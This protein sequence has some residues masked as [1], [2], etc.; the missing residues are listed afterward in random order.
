MLSNLLALLGPSA[1]AVPTVSAPSAGTCFQ[2]SG[3]TATGALVTVYNLGTVQI[4]LP[5][6]EINP[7]EDG[8]VGLGNASNQAVARATSTTGDI[9]DASDV[10]GN[11]FSF[12]PPTGTNF[13]IVP[14]FNDTGANTTNKLRSVSATITGAKSQDS[15]NG[16]SDSDLAI[17][18]GIVTTGTSGVG[19]AIVAIAKDADSSSGTTAGV[20]TY[21]KSGTS[22]N[23]ATISITGLGLAIPPSG[24]GALSGTLQAT[25]DPTPPTGIG[26]SGGIATPTVASAISGLSGTI[27]ICTVTSPAGELQ[28]ELDADGTTSLYNKTGASAQSNLLALGQIGTATSVSVFDTA[29]ATAVPSVDLEPIIIRGKAG[30]GTAA[31][32]QV[33]ATGELL[34]DVDSAAEAPSATALDTTTLFGNSVVSPI[35]VAFSDDNAAATTTLNAVDLIIDNSNAAAAPTVAGFST[36]PTSR[37]G[38][39]GALR[40]AVFESGNAGTN[41]TFATG[42]DTAWGVG[43]ISGGEGATGTGVD[44]QES[45]E[46]DGTSNLAGFGAI[47]MNSI[48]PFNN[49][50]VDLRLECG[51]NTNPVAGW[52]AVLNSGAGTLST[53]VATIQ[54]IRASQAGGKILVESQTNFFSQSLT[55]L[56]GTNPA[57]SFIG[58]GNGAAALATNIRD[59]AILYASCS[60]NTLTILPIQNGFDG[61]RDTISVTPRFTV[62]NVSNTFSSDINVIAQVSGNN[63]TGTTTLNLAKLV[64]VPVTGQNST[65]ASAE[66]VA[67]SESSQL[68]VDCSSGGQSSV[69]LA[70]ITTGSVATSVSS[71]CTSGAIAPAPPFWTGGAPASVSGTTVVDG[72]PVVQG[73][74]RGVLVSETTATG[75]S[76]LVNQVGGGVT[77]T[78][79]EIALP[80]GCDIIDDLDDNNTAST[81]GNTAPVGNDVAR[82]TVTSTAG[83]TASNIGGTGDALLTSA[84]SLAPKSG[85]TAAKVNFRLSAATGTG[86]DAVV[87]DSVLVRLD[88]QDIFCPKSEDGK[89]LDA[90]VI[91]KNKVSNPTITAN[92]GTANLGTAMT[93]LTF[94]FGDDVA[95]STKGE[96]STNSMIGATPRLVGGGATT[97]HTL[98]VTEGGPRGIPIGGRVSARNLDPENSL[99]SSVITRGQL[100]IIPSSSSAFSTAPAASD[101]TFSDNSLTTD[102]SPTIATSSTVNPNV[103]IGTLLIGVKK[104]TASGAAAPESSTTT[105]TVKN[106][107]L[108]SAT[109]SDADLIASVGVF[110]Q[111]AGVI[112]NTPGAI[113]GNSASS[114]TLFTPYVQ[115]STKALNQLEV[116]GVQLGT[117][118]LANSLL[119]SRL[120]IAEAPQLS[121]FAKTISSAMGADTTKITVA[122]EGITDSTDNV[123]TVTGAAGAVD[124][125]AEVA[126]TTGGSTAFDSVTVVASDDGSFTAKV[127]GDCSSA[128]S[129]TVT[130]TGSVSGTSTASV[131]KTALCSGSPGGVDAELAKIDG[132]G[133]GSFTVDEVLS[134]ITTEGG[135]AAVVSAGGDKLTAVI[136]A[137]KGALGLS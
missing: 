53:T 92:L 82:V 54:G 9:D 96:T 109:S 116:A 69:V 16:V 65:L 50:F 71:A 110:L 52:F 112:V 104:N 113:A 101:V 35:T 33:F 25:L 60:N 127:R 103:P 45:A 37:H 55:N 47:T 63:L 98:A 66:G 72:S 125:G 4:S 89:Q 15:T 86:T 14:G 87:T 78:V 75:F 59:N 99:L 27:N 136:Q 2:H 84:N 48:E 130:A 117:G 114:P 23:T 83:V 105:V 11:V 10:I 56:A 122:S 91:A 3:T 21:P 81:D 64:G 94:A 77:G 62:S 6:N 57:P 74:P 137:V 121:P 49:T 126:V 97:S 102:G 79:F 120:A 128:S 44:V 36:V 51:S 42:S 28:A 124:G 118:S 95:T 85:S 80:S 115:A 133:D 132:D 22:G 8:S 29:T 131:T 88:A 20:E 90:P 31:R 39:L 100:L 43:S 73:E 19:R 34:T 17:S 76:E 111:D 5:N 13:V 26:L 68:G 119:T 107:K 7:G 70:G 58:V 134:Y 1:Q 106:L 123:V 24:D 93:A 41:T 30:T 108:A 129:I 18:V 46:A 40:A 12:K 32:D 135:L 61:E 38:F 67:V